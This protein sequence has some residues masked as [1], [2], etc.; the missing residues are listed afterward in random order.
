MVRIPTT[1]PTASCDYLKNRNLADSPG[2]LS[3]DRCCHEMP[4]SILVLQG[5]PEI[6]L[7]NMRIQQAS[8]DRLTQAELLLDRFAGTPNLPADNLFAEGNSGS[9]VA[10]RYREYLPL[11]SFTASAGCSSC[12]PRGFVGIPLTHVYRPRHRLRIS[13]SQRESLAWLRNSRG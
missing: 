11:V 12:K 2:F 1:I 10:V 6:I 7:I 3:G 4:G 9:K 5:S 8:A 13:S